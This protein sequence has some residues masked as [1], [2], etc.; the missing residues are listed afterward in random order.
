MWF[1]K[2]HVFISEILLPGVFA[3]SLAAGY[4]HTCV[5]INRGGALCWG[6]NNN[7]QLGTGDTE[8]RTSPAAAMLNAGKMKYNFSV[9]KICN[10]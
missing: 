1:E 3:T 2:A 8:S 10:D 4:Y 6:L 7:G 5:A 9:A